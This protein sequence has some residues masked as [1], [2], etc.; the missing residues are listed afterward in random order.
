VVLSLYWSI[1]HVRF[2]RLWL[3][4]LPVESRARARDIW[5]AVEAG[6]GAYI[7][8]EGSLS[9]I[10]GVIIWLVYIS[11]GIEYATLLALVGSVVRLIPWLGLVLV[12]VL[13]LLAG[14]IYGIWA[15]LT[16]S[17]LTLSILILLE[18]L[19]GNKL[20]PSSRYSSLLLMIIV[21]VLAES[22]GLVGAV[23][24]PILAVA[25]QIFVKK[26]A[27]VHAGT[28]NKETQARF[29]G[30]Q[31]KMEK[32]KQMAAELDREDST[33]SINLVSRLET[34]I[35]KANGVNSGERAG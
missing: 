31:P 16:A 35:Q 2:E 14:S 15:A 3:S 4:L 27:P 29:A 22:Y 6:V 28:E 18:V 5:F 33:H 26:L 25:L 32:I 23:F 8:R 11:L 1:D 17:G 10:G 13:P 12:V 24:A 20:L 19:V 7:R 21:I 30:L 34:L 9:V